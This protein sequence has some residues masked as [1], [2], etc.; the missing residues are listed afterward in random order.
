MKKGT[1]LCVVLCMVLLVANIVSADIYMKQKQKTGAFA[2]MGQK[3]PAQEV[4]TE[5]WIA[6]N[7]MWTKMGDKGMLMKEDGGMIMFD[8]VKKTYTEMNMNPEKMAAASG[9]KMD[10]EDKADF[11]KLMGK[12]MDIKVSVQATGEKKKIN[13]YNCGKYIQTMDMGMGTNKSI[14]WATTDIKVDAD[15]YAKFTASMLA[16]QPGMEKSIDQ[17]EKE[18]KKIKGVQVLNETS[19]NIMGQ[20]MKTTVELLEIKQGKAPGKVLSIPKGYKKKALGFE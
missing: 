1:L 20:E 9:R 10:A 7:A 19:M 12:M 16:N 14:I 13:G 17:I 5:S 11:K 8:H 6:D 3:Q 15:V 4:I 2:M 18:M